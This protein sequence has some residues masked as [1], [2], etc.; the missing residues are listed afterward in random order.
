MWT[1]PTYPPPLPPPSHPTHLFLSLCLFSFL[2]QPP[3]PLLHTSAHMHTRARVRARTHTHTHIHTRTHA[4]THTH[5]HTHT[6]TQK[7]R[8]ERGGEV[9]LEGGRGLEGEGEKRVNINSCCPV[10]LGTRLTRQP[11]TEHCTT[12]AHTHT[13]THTHIE[14]RREGRG[15]GKGGGWE[16][17]L[18]GEGGERESKLLTL[19]VL[20]HMEP[21]ELDSHTLNNA[22]RLKPFLWCVRK[23]V[24]VWFS[25]F[26]KDRTTIKVSVKDPFLR[27]F[28]LNWYRVGCG[29]SHFQQEIKS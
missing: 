2:P 23:E 14:K 27:Y 22:P 17:G 21:H 16:G 18:E 7:K 19:A 28:L 8:R 20:Y 29:S 4:R 24:I 13:H 15:G 10:P 3:I 25:C 11:Y 12:R 5:T 9:R 6:H 26:F 1:F